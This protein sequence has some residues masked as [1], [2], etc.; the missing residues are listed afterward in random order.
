MLKFNQVTITRVANGW[1]L[2]RYVPEAGRPSLT[3][4]DQWVYYS[5]KDLTK[6]LTKLLHNETLEQEL[7]PYFDRA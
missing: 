5:V 4:C 7:K 3:G 1:L 6:G 2:Q